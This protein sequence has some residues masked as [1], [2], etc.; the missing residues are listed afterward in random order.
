MARTSPQG[1]TARTTARRAHRSRLRRDVAGGKGETSWTGP[2]RASKRCARWIVVDFL[3]ART[4]TTAER[5]RGKAGPNDAEPAALSRSMART[6]SSLPR[7]P[8]PVTVCVVRHLGTRNGRLD[9][10]FLVPFAVEISAA[11][12][13]GPIVGLRHGIR[14]GPQFT[15]GRGMLVFAFRHAKTLPWHAPWQQEAP[16][17]E[18]NG[19][20]LRYVG[21]AYANHPKRTSEMATSRGSTS[22]TNDTERDGIA[23]SSLA[24]VSTISPSSA[25]TSSPSLIVRP[26]FEPRKP[27]EGGGR[28]LLGFGQHRGIVSRRP[29]RRHPCGHGP[30]RKCHLLQEGKERGGPRRGPRRQGQATGVSGTTFHGFA[31]VFQDTGADSGPRKGGRCRSWRAGA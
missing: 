12:G 26:D 20:R 24:I 21:F 31:S 2:S 7:I 30:W 10:P 22:N 13:Q 18:A 17:G 19:G 11:H 16:H 25:V 29:S 4:G 3:G 23:T 27:N 1:A 5:R 14:S 6:C 28:A 8:F 9:V 15:L